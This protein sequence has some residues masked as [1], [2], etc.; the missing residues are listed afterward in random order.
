MPQLIF[1]ADDCGLSPGINRAVVDLHQRGLITAASVMTNFPAHEH[2][3]ELFRAYPEL[4]VGAHLTLTDGVPASIFGPPHSH[5]LHDDRSFRNKFSLYC[6]GL[7]FNKSAIRWIRNELDLQ[8]RRIVDSG[9]RLRHITTHHHFHT[10]PILREIVHELAALYHVEW[11]RG[12]DFRATLAPRHIMLRNQ[13]QAER[14]HFWLPDYMTGVQGWMQRSPAEMAAAIMKLDGRVEIVAH[15]GLI[16]DPEFPHGVGYG[17]A[18]RAAETAYLEE[19]VACL[20]RSTPPP[21]P[22]RRVREGSQNH[23]QSNLPPGSSGGPR[24]VE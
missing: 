18:E 20:R 4:D 16:D 14:Y 8:L 19:L 21:A 10:L 6:R 24:R 2:A 9:L 12:H 23:A 3:L 15:P 7:F 1:T 17:P 11:V 5:L 13:R 22:P